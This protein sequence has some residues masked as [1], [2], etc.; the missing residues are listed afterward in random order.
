[1][2]LSLRVANSNP[3]PVLDMSYV[4]AQ[5]VIVRLHISTYLANDPLLVV[6][7]AALVKAKAEPLMRLLWAILLSSDCV[8]LGAAE[9]FPCAPKCSL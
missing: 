6:A 4:F 3:K 8:S 1:M 2:N 9:C 5:M 7:L